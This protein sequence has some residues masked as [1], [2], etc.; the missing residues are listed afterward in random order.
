MKQSLLVGIFTILFFI[1]PEKLSFSKQVSEEILYPP[2]Q[3]NTSLE[4]M[5][6]SWDS[7]IWH[8]TD[9]KNAVVTDIHERGLKESLTVH[10]KFYGSI[11]V[12]I[13]LSIIWSR[14]RKR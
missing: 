7:L 2:K 1:V 6:M 10:S 12:F 5:K 4:D 3:K 8:A 14:N 13:I 11:F 9:L